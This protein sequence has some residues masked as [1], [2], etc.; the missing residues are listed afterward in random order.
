MRTTW[1]PVKWNDVVSLPNDNI[2]ISS[3]A[4]SAIWQ[5]RI[6]LCT[7][8]CRLK[9]SNIHELCEPSRVYSTPLDTYEHPSRVYISLPS[10]IRDISFKLIGMECTTE[11][12]HIVVEVALFL[13]KQQHHHG[14]ARDSSGIQKPAL[15]N[16]VLLL[17]HHFEVDNRATGQANLHAQMRWLK[18]PCIHVSTRKWNIL[19]TQRKKSWAQKKPNRAHFP[20]DGKLCPHS[21][22]QCIC[23]D[24]MWWW[25]DAKAHRHT[26]HY[27]RHNFEWIIASQK[28]DSPFFS[29]QYDKGIQISTN[30]MSKYIDAT[31]RRS[32]VVQV[33]VLFLFVW[34]LT[35]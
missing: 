33:I 7:S 8:L 14:C 17:L 6:Y 12:T 1:A 3:I 29:S 27:V 11:K 31:S 19:R 9:Y 20:S 21:L 34:C 18:T 4:I 24:E 32:K 10:S 16:L 22:A 15:S 26:C 25:H 35:K 2:N 5:Q 23:V 30:G 28:L 13:A